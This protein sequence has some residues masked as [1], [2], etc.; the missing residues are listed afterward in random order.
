MAGAP[1]DLLLELCTD[2]N[3]WFVSPLTGVEYSC[4]FLE[5]LKY[6]AVP[7]GVCSGV[8][9]HVGAQF[10]NHT[11]ILHLDRGRETG[12]DLPPGPGSDPGQ[13]SDG[14]AG[15]PPCKLSL[16]CHSTRVYSCT[17][18]AGLTSVYSPV[19]LVESSILHFIASCSLLC[20]S[21]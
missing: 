9:G 13:L 12:D 5:S 11:V 4:D 10:G 15:C 1:C 21:G 6:P 3:Q 20:A 17:S 14:T 19:I 2:L 8:P 18:P 16:P 7:L